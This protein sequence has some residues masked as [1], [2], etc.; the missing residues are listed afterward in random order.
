MAVML[1]M[2]CACADLGEVKI[3]AIDALRHLNKLPDNTKGSGDSTLP[4][5]LARCRWWQLMEA[6]QQLPV[7]WRT[8]FPC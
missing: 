7:I 5:E 1:V 3:L 6:S 2:H 4:A 8:G